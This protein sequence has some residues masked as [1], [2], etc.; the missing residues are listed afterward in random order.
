MKR[1]LAFTAACFFGWTS[2]GCNPRQPAYFRESGDLSYYIDRATQ[3]EYPDVA[4]APLEEVSQNEKPLTLRNPEFSEFWDLPL[5]D[6]VS[7][8]LQNSKVIRGYGTPGLQGSVVAPGVDSLANNPAGA[9]TTFNVAVRESE[10]GFLSVPGQVSPGSSITTNTGLESQQGVESAL[11]E[12]DTHFTT[13]MFLDKTDRPRNTIP[14][15]PF[16]PIVFEQDAVAFQAQLGKKAANGTQFF[17]RNTTDYT[18]NNIPALF[19][20]LDSFYTT[21]LEAEVRQPLLRG[22]GTMI[23]RMPVVVARIGTDQEIANLEAQLQNMVTNVEIRYWNLYTAYRFY[24]AAKAGEDSAQVTYANLEK[25]AVVG[26]GDDTPRALAQAREQYFFFRSQR[27]QALADL[28]DAENNLRW[29][30]GLANSDSRM[31]RPADEP[32]SALVQF[33][34]MEAYDE[35]L[36]LRPELRLER[37]ELKKKELQL[38]YARNGLLPRFDAVLLYRWLGLGD[39]LVA[40]DRNGINF[41]SE[42]SRAW[43]ELTG[44]NFQ[45]VR[46]GLEFGVP[47]GLRRELANIRNAQ[48]KLARE[49]ARM[50]DMELDVQRELALVY[51]ALETNYELAKDHLNRWIASDEEVRIQTVK[52]SAGSVSID[53][54][55]DAQRR[56]AQTQIAYYQSLAE[57]NKCIALLHRRKGTALQYC[58]VEFDE[59]AWP[60]KAYSDAM[61]RARGRSAAREL[62]YGFREPEVVTRGATGSPAYP[63]VGGEVIEG[64]M[65]YEGELESIGP[66][67]SGQP[68]PV[69]PMAPTPDPGVSSGSGAS[70]APRFDSA[71]R[72]TSMIVPETP[73]PPMN[74]L[75]S[76]TSDTVN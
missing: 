14:T 1:Y 65:I 9:G 24:E 42:N 75:R 4:A 39:E 74:G 47:I 5:E 44:G 38:A 19:Q 67:E 52:E 48:L 13:S 11:A 57:Y 18:R 69:E 51:R 6:A 40:S 16:S 60:S 58:G 72:R 50:E 2:A 25:K 7:I 26:Q 15:N 64:E 3:V 35:A 41:P 12:F 34:W 36:G 31:I 46:A 10:P 63:A 32:T 27:N 70:S 49:R 66:A 23:N 55:L 37:W 28:M 68:T 45:E 54:V 21:T 20:P 43:E 30:L 17:F 73:I 53:L 22:R 71:V 8:A 61:D 56:R 33:D 59:G 62:N 29:L 76:S